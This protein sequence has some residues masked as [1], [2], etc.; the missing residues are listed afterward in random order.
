MSVPPGPQRT[1]EEILSA[2]LEAHPDPS[3]AEVEALCAEHP[4]LAADLRDL[5]KAHRAVGAAFPSTLDEGVP[6]LHRA[7]RPSSAPAASGFRVEAGMTLGDFTLVRILGRGGMG[8]VWEAEQLS[9]S[10]RVA[11]KLLLPERVD[12]KGLDFFA[13]EARAG[14]RLSHPGIV[15]IHGTGED[16]G[17]HWISMELVEEA[18]DLRR[19]LDGIRE[20]D[21]LPA[22]HY[23]CVAQFV[24]ETADALETAHA[25]GVIHRD[26][27]PGNILVTRDDR[28]KVL[29]FGL[30]KLVDEQSISEVG[31]VVGTYFY[32]SP[33]QV[34]ARRAGLDHRTDIFSLGVVLYEMLTLVRPFEGDTTEQVAHKILVI[35][36]PSAKE[37][38]SK[39]PT[40]LAVICGK[41]LE[42]D[43]DQRYGSMAE[44]AADLRRHLANEPIMARPPTAVQRAVK[45]VR[46][47]PTRSVAGTVAVAALVVISWLGLVAIENANEARASQEQAARDARL[48]MEAARFLGGVFSSPR[49]GILG[50]DVRAVDVLDDAADKLGDQFANSPRISAFLHG[51]I[52]KSYH[53]LGRIED[54]IEHFDVAT[55]VDDL[56]E[57]D[58]RMAANLHM[59]LSLMHRY[60]GDGSGALEALEEARRIAELHLPEDIVL[61]AVIE[62]DLGLI[63]ARAGTHALDSFVRIAAPLMGLQPEQAKAHF[64]KSIMEV[65]AHWR[66]GERA[67]AVA[68]I[69]ALAAPVAAIPG[70][71]LNAGRALGALTETLRRMGDYS[72]AIPIAMAARDLLHERTKEGHPWAL[73]ESVRVGYIL[74]C[75]EHFSAAEAELL[76]ALADCRE[77][78]G[79]SHP[80]TL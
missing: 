13:R 75:A 65:R 21:E 60:D 79:G 43:R 68:Q 51:T 39:V 61:L 53:S 32:M 45:W 10:R 29:D 80:I 24:A 18:C 64:E 47:N 22:D 23:R 73:N 76:A 2:F 71:S 25:A 49:P 72:A 63:K 52:G 6:G 58:P 1:P 59:S 36:P 62:G 34:A 12:Q 77:H 27:K 9:L 78:L 33:E 26:L 44:L 74:L 17:L 30:A 8:E 54:A 20:E 55:R 16:E 19:S 11:L 31:D 5:F 35:D 48:A 41:A 3:P 56:A 42:K 38:R 7:A 14:G 15:A 50:K 4:D 46:R 69:R 57:I 66:N 37:V 70:M 40:D 67:E 28:A